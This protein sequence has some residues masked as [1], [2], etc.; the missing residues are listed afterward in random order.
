MTSLP[1][2]PGETYLGITL[3]DRNQPNFHVIKLPGHVSGVNFDDAVNWARSKNGGL[4]DTDELKMAVIPDRKVTY[5]TLDIDERNANLI[6]SYHPLTSR[7]VRTE[8]HIKGAA[9][10]VRRVPVA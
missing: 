5:W 3:D 4:P 8:K 2:N 10:A 7:F 6:L 9:I 1:M